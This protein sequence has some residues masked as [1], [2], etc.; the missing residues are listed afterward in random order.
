VKK[1]EET[2]HHGDLANA[3]IKEALRLIESDGP[4]AFSLRE[5]ARRVGVSPNA[6]YRHFSDRDALIRA[7]SERGFATL[8]E[9]MRRSIADVKASTPRLRAIRC[10]K[11]TGRAYIEFALTNPAL[12]RVTFGAHTVLPNSTSSDAAH[13]G[14]PYSVLSSSLDALVEVGALPKPRRPGAEVKAWVTVHGHASLALSRV[15]L[16]TSDMIE[17]VLDFVVEGLGVV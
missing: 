13:D 4:D 12:F 6:A 17:R 10:L 7:I 11:A 3:L 8:L 1:S 2:Y 5:V 15:D 9:H 14:D 16:Q